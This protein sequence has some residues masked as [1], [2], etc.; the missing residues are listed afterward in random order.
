MAIKIGI[1]D[2]H[3]LFLDSL[4]SLLKTFPLIRV[5]ITAENGLELRT[6]MRVLEVL[7]NIMLVDVNM[8]VMNGFETTKWLKA[9]YPS[10]KVVAL[11]MNDD[12]LSIIKMIRAG[13]C[14]Y[15]L[16]GI[17]GNEL[18]SALYSIYNTGKYINDANSRNSRK[19]I[20]EMGD[21]SSLYLTEQEETFIKYACSELNYKEISEL[22][23]ISFRTVDHHRETVFAKLNV[24][25]RVGLCMEAIRL[26]LVVL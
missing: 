6:K 3:R 5:S 14:S 15:L 11:S 20:S 19:I 24:N 17:D 8:P 16:K 10:I 9:E 7:P 18:E 4:V 21:E 2:D 12:D 22:M 13:C 25:T 26:K 23:N 1:V